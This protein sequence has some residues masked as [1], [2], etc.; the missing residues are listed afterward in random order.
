MTTTKDIPLPALGEGVTQATFVEWL[1]TPGTA[2]AQGDVLA[3]AMTDK[4]AMEVEAPEAGT[5]A[6]TLV[7]PDQEVPPGT[8]LGRYI[9]G[10]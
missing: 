5:L 1:V 7:A 2:F 9:V 3:E 6:E 8:V 10:G 4:V